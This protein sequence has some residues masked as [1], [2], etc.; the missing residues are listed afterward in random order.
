MA[1]KTKRQVQPVAPMRT[2]PRPSPDGDDPCFQCGKP[3]SS[4]SDCGVVVCSAC[5]VT[6]YLLA[7]HQPV[8]HVQMDPE[9][10]LPEPMQRPRDQSRAKDAV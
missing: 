1:T 8:E 10:R 7:G 5:N 4:C 6:P 3:G 9:S 2:E